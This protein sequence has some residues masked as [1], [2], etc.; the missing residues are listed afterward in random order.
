VLS[1]VRPHDGE[2]SVLGLSAVDWNFL[3]WALFFVFNIGDWIG[4]KLAHYRIIRSD[5]EVLLLVIASARI[6][7]YPLILFGLNTT[8]IRTNFLANKYALILINLIFSI[9]SGYM[10]SLPMSFAPEAIERKFKNTNSESEISDAKSRGSTYM[11]VFLFGGL[12]T[13]SLCSFIPVYNIDQEIKVNLKQRFYDFLMGE[14][15]VFD[16]FIDRV[17]QRL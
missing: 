17:N 4:K 15:Y 13:G 2:K 11:L 6:M 14:S 3:N 1:K 12:V 10:G 5:Q 8:G 9:S 16:S 7:F